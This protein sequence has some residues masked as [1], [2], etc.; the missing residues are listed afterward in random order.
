MD[1]L[2][3]DEHLQLKN[4]VRSF[5]E[6]HCPVSAP[7]E[8]VGDDVLDR[9]L[10]MKVCGELGLLG[11]PVPEHFGGSGYGL[12]EFGY[13]MEEAGRALLSVPLLSTAIAVQCLLLSGDQGTCMAHL[14]QIVSGE[15]CATVAW[16]ASSGDAS[17]PRARRTAEGWTISGLAGFVLDGHLDGVLI[18]FCDTADGPT[19]FLIG[20]SAAGVQRRR[21][22]T[23]DLTRPQA[24]IS[25]ED[26]PATTLGCLGEGDVLRA[27]LF[28]RA[29]VLLA[30]EQ[31]GAAE[32]C[33]EMSVEYAKTR[34][35]FGR[36]IGSFQAIK[37]KC[38]DM[39]ARVEAARAAARYALVAADERAEQLSL[40]TLVAS[41]YVSEALTFT[42]SENIQVHGGI[43]FTWEHP[44][45][46]YYRRA[47]SSELLF[48]R[49][50]DAREALVSTLGV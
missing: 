3:T 46:L 17:R 22:R 25:F 32:K 9:G 41:S 13:V 26:A 43:G 11:L 48:L 27:A 47:K 31:V 19:A 23:L 4:V 50:R 28:E 44:A 5:F 45:H 10:W 8:P 16:Q 35:Q 38:A 21:L 37:H 18:V 20:Q 15:Q 34:V 40:A 7:P 49:P 24:E 39:Y 30:C 12:R 1:H 29:C 33:L 14:P 36:T 6:D 2:L 42:A